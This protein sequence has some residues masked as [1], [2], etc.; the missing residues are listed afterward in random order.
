MSEP[1]FAADE[2]VALAGGHTIEGDVPKTLRTLMSN[3][4]GSVGISLRWRS[5]VKGGYL[6][7]R[8]VKGARRM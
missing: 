1:L 5:M 8:D 2:S 7:E 4:R 6:T 3:E